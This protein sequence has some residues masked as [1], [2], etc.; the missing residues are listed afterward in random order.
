[1][2][3][4]LAGRFYRAKSLGRRRVICKA[5]ARV[6]T[7]PIEVR[8]SYDRSIWIAYRDGRY[9][10]SSTVSGSAGTHFDGVW[11]RGWM[12]LVL[13]TKT[14]NRSSATLM[15]LRHWRSTFCRA[16]ERAEAGFTS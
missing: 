9:P 5:D 8:N 3:D 16:V 1:V 4:A 6:G 15:F 14:S 7:T 10:T 13:M 12:K 2:I 11:E